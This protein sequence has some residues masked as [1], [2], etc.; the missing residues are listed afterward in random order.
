MLASAVSMLTIMSCADAM[1]AQEKSEIVVNND[2]P[3]P[4]TMRFEYA[5]RNLTWKLAEEPMEPGGSLIYRFPVNIP[6][7]DKLREWHITDGVLSITNARG[8]VCTKRI[9]LCDRLK[10][11]M[12]V[13]GPACYWT[14]R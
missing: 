5:F 8:L 4:V 13:Q 11:T 12:E 2:R 6:G 14:D 10:S 7:C 3:E 1:A 9:S